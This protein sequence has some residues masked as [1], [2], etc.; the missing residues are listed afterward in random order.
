M[1]LSPSEILKKYWGFS[2]FRPLQDEIINS[3][4]EGKDTLALLPTGGG[5]SICFQV[6][7]LAKEGICIVVSPLIAL[8]KDQVENLQKRG[9]KAKTVYTG[10][11]RKD[12]DATLD[13]C[14]YS[15]VKFL[16]LSPERLNTA[17][18][19]ARVL[20]M[21]VSLIAV[22]EAHCVS[23]WGYDFRPAYLKIAEVRELLPN[24]PLIALTASATPKVVHDIQSKLLF[25]KENLFQQSFARSNLSYVVRKTE[26]KQLLLLDILK[27]VAGTGI[28]Y[29]RNRKRTKELA[30]YLLKN[31]VSA[32][33]YHAGLTTDERSKKQN[34]WIANKTKVI[35][36]TNAFG[37]GI[38]KPDVRAVVHYEPVE[39]PEAYYQ[40]AGRAGRD[41][42]RSFAVQVMSEQDLFSLNEQKEKN[43]PTP[44]EVRD[45][46]DQI[47]GYLSIAYNDGSGREYDFDL[48]DFCKKFSYS[49]I[50]VMHGLKLLESQEILFF[51][52]GLLETPKV[53]IIVDKEVLYKFQ[54]ENRKYEPLIK[55][56]LRT[57]PG[58]FEDAVTFNETILSEK[59]KQTFDTTIGMLTYLNNIDI[60]SYRPRREKP[61]LILLQDR[62][63]REDVK[64]D[65]DYI[66]ERMSEYRERIKAVQKYLLNTLVCRSRML[67]HYFGEDNTSDCGV[68]DIC[69]TRKKAH[70]ST[71]EFSL[72]VNK[73]ENLVKVKSHTVNELAD[74]LNT[75]A[76]KIILII[77]WLAECSTITRDEQGGI[78]WLG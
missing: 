42:V 49:P 73:I 71:E 27:K 46:Y 37:M 40:E 39:S 8:M 15:D 68:C 31:K 72:L 74:V 21:K 26:N 9:I 18:F 51:S 57:C 25:K 6:P 62:V 7:A 44:K 38:D 1:S 3:V 20:K 16:Y 77:E 75:K 56:I 63:K 61:Q 4:L 32:D 24:I 5:K 28:V 76:E 29:V 30:D 33:F 48:S 50:K 34:N 58:V 67:L 13:T 45:M 65:T 64:L 35:V 54:V 10:M 2:E 23:Q 69:L 12:I 41:G 70:L 78:Q 60:L 17:E 52:E 47:L 43:F 59:L 55:F 66:S 22:D 14:A 19:K 11:S 36:C 53:K